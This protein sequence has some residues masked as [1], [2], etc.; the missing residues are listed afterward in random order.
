MTVL[1]GARVVT[2]GRILD[3]GWVEIE[4]GRITFVGAGAPPRA[5]VDLDGGWLLPG[6]IDVHVHGGGGADVTKG[7]DDMAPRKAAK[8]NSGPGMACAAPYPARKSVL[9]TMPFATVA[10][11]SRGSTTWPP[12]NTSA[13]AR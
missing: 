7:P 3:P 9:E 2:P 4:H 6:F 11:S 13:P 8:A 10:D 1:A 12:P 5:D